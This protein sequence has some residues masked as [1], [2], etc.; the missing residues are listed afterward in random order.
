RNLFLKYLAIS[1]SKITLPFCGDVIKGS[2]SFDLK[3]EISKDIWQGFEKTEDKVDILNET[4]DVYLDAFILFSIF[5]KKV[6]LFTAERKAIN[7]FSRELS[8][9]KSKVLEAILKSN[10]VREFVRERMYRYQKPI[11]DALAMSEDLLN[12]SK[13]KSYFAFLAEELEEIIG[14][15][16]TVSEY[17]DLRYRPDNAENKN[18][19]MYLS[20]SLV[21]SLSN[22][23][24][25]LKHVAQ[26]NDVIIIDEPELNLHPD[27]QRKIARFFG[28]LVNEGFKVVIS[29]HSD[30][31]IKEINNLIMLKKD[32][33]HTKSL[34]KKF[35]YLE[36]E[37]I[38]FSQVEALLFKQNTG[39]DYLVIPEQIEVTETGLNVKTID[40]VI[41]NLEYT[42]ETI[43]YKLFESE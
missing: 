39:T 42:A 10:T 2:N 36:N 20:S 19:E 7:L 17:G 30:Y 4:M 26:K 3:I 38:H 9:I 25:Y 29:T 22:L 1:G 43:Y 31:I 32:N 5:Q 37:L 12:L 24:F 35:N 40:D 11:S 23:A 21:K 14:G 6:I 33:K 15:K 13:N 27:N 8:I 41:D 28:R 16:I 18:L 34:L